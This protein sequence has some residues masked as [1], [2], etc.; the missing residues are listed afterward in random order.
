V[1]GGVEPGGEQAQVAYLDDLDEAS[2]SFSGHDASPG[3][4]WKWRY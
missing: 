3:T 2:R 1:I 4:V